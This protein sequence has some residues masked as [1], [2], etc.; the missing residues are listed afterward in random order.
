[1]SQADPVFPFKHPEGCFCTR[2]QIIF[3]FVPQRLQISFAQRSAT[4]ALYELAISDNTCYRKSADSSPRAARSA[5]T[6]LRITSK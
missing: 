3:H 2:G 1:M 6:R 4:P 5:S